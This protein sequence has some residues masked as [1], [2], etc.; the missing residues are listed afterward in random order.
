LK[1]VTGDPLKFNP[2]TDILL[3]FNGHSIVIR[4]YS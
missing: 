1:K 3:S 4:C 2:D